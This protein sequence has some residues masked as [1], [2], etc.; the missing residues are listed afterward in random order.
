MLEQKII[1]KSVESRTKEEVQR[2]EEQMKDLQEHFA[3]SDFEANKRYLEWGKKD[4]FP[5]IESALLNSA[6]IIEYANKTGMVHP[7][8]VNEK[9]IRGA[10]FCVRIA[11]KCVWWD[12]E[13]IK[14][15]K[16]LK[17]GETITIKKDS[18][19]FITLKPYF[20]V[21]E[22]LILR[23]NLKIDHVYKGLLL[24]TGP[25]VDPGFCGKISIPLHNLTSNDYK[26]KY[27]EKL[28][29]FEVTKLSRH[30]SWGSS[31][32]HLNKNRIN[33]S[34][35]PYKNSGPERDVNFFISDAVSGNVERYSD[36]SE[37]CHVSSVI[38]K[39]IRDMEEKI[40]N[41]STQSANAHEEVRRATRI[42][43]I[44]I[45]SVIISMLAM[46]FSVLMPV[47]NMVNDTKIY[48]ENE[49]TNHSNEV[50]DLNNKIDQLREEIDKYKEEVSQLEEKQNKMLL[51]NEDTSE[52]S[53][54]E[55]D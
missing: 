25:V 15:E 26:F 28:V 12:E 55:S 24:G 20:R 22:Y 11:G 6:D 45:A 27:D 10:T 29:W 33:N 1:N 42:G 9:S 54:A 48:L 38:P 4:P 44:A 35:I 53:T 23:F 51:K 39:E 36:G 18:I 30:M 32:N 13:N 14:H 2:L 52:P 34:Q 43:I 47:I 31:L 17:D 46:L 41:N 40:E 5:E 37:T 8:E 21:P 7:F 50:I 3:Q 49:F 19:F 16:E